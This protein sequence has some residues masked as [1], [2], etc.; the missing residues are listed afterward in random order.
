[1]KSL[2][3]LSAGQGRW[4]F[5]VNQLV[6]VD[7]A[8]MLSTYQCAALTDQAQVAGAKIVLVG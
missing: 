1:M 3:A 5:R 7:E 6:I 8:S 2:A 4:H